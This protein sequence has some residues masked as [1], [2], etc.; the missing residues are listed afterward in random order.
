MNNYLITV[1]AAPVSEPLTLD[2]AKAQLRLTSGFTA[3]D[4]YITALIKVA[5]DHAEKYC[6]RFFTEQTIALNYSGGV[7]DVIELPFPDLASVSSFKYYDS[8]GAEQTI[9][10][11]G[12]SLDSE[13]QIITVT[14][15]PSGSAGY[16]VELVTG[17]PVEF[18]GA[19]QAMLM[20]LTDLYELRTESVIG[21]PVAENP[22]VKALYY[23]YRVN[24]GI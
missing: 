6:N 8:E 19:K 2:E 17:A 12:Y 15:P 18:E 14:S 24:L 9:D 21:A 22:A 10:P 13:R 3:D 11:S 23:P 5:R 20:T 4:T 1:I 7:P 16:R